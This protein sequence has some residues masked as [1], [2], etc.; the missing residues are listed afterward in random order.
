MTRSR[1]LTSW[2]VWGRILFLFFFFS[3]L[4]TGPTRISRP[5]EKESIQS[6]QYIQKKY[7]TKEVPEPDP[8]YWYHCR[9]TNRL[10]KR[11][12]ASVC[13]DVEHLELT[14][15]ADR[16]GTGPSTSIIW[17]FYLIKLVTHLPYDPSVS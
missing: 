14:L 6:S 15:I 12:N 3:S 9:P 16:N 17:Q 1:V 2:T 10:N 5:K 8:G 4:C 11:H 13:E 7:W